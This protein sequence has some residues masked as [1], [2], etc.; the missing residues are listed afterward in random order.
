MSAN[1]T[2]RALLASLPLSLCRLSGDDALLDGALH[3]ICCDSRRAAAGDLFVCI[4]GAKS[5]GH[6][7]IRAAYANGC[8]AFLVQSDAACEPLPKDALVL[9]ADDTRTAL[10]HLAC[11]FY[12]HPARS[13][14]VVGITGTKGKT[15]VAMT[16]YHILNSLG[17]PAGYVGTC[18]VRYGKV[19]TST[20]NTTPGPL[21]LQRTL[22]DMKCAG[23][24]TV[25]LEVSSQGLWQHR[26]DG[27]AFDVCV[28]TNL[29]SDH[30]GPGEHPSAAHY[31]ACKRRLLTDFGAPVLIANADDAAS[32][33]LLADVS[34]HIVR[35]G[36]TEGA[37]LRADNVRTEREGMLPYTTFDCY[38][39]RGSCASVH[40]PLPGEHN[41]Q[42]ALFALTIVRALGISISQAAPTL[43]GLRI[44]GR[45]DMLEVKGALVVID[46]AHN[47]A[48]LRAA[49]SALRALAPDRLLCLFGSVGER[50]QCRRAELGAA[51][52]ELADFTY[53]TAD[54][55]HHEPVED[56]C[57][58]IALAFR[59]A[60]LPRYTV[61]ADRAAA[62][63]TALDELHAG[64]V[65]LI[66]GKGDEVVQRIRGQALPHS[67][68]AVVEDYAQ[69]LMLTV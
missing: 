20:G 50:T 23:V 62:I 48:S 5:D 3:S 61:I 11:A 67:D 68:R 13:M 54:D 14:R 34:G 57:R 41:V 10:A 44:P 66:A 56:I 32:L 42:N 55:P 63:R 36:L 53:L 27:I 18:G 65:L 22:H 26:V 49:L 39:E 45:F 9:S 40:L 29:F 17:M 38:D 58:D 6:D 15:T 59:P 8:R 24:D 37:Q 46:Y 60:F 19:Q 1:M 43:R 64:D 47:G 30:V 33:S 69:Q 52:D 4:R 35:C 12:G 31:A 16:C 7:F 28:L 21:E 51:A 25:F 2:L